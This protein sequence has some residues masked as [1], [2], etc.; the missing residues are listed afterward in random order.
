MDES[1]PRQIFPAGAQIFTEGEL[2]R[3]AYAIERGKV[4]ITTTSQGRRIALAKLGD[5]D[6]LGEMA[7]IDDSPR[8][9][10][11]IALEDTQVIVFERAALW[12][13]LSQADPLVR[14]LLAGTLDR[15]RTT[16]KV[17]L[18][19]SADTLG[20]KCRAG[21]VRE[22]TALESDLA[23]AIETESLSLHFQPIVRLTDGRVDGFEA[24]VRWEHPDHGTVVPSSFIKLA[25]ET[26]MI[27]PLGRWMLQKALAAQKEFEHAVN[28]AATN[29]SPY[30][31]VNISSRQLLHKEEVEDLIDL[32][33][34]SGVASE[35]VIFE[36]TETLLVEDPDNVLE[37]MRHF[38]A[39]GIRIA[40]D[41][42]GTG[43]ANLAFLNR[44]PLDILKIDRSFITNMV[45]DSR[46]R[47]IV[48]TIINLAQDFG[49]SIIAE[50]IEAEAE[51]GVLRE[52]GCDCGQGFLLSR[53][54]P[55]DQAVNLVR[56]RVRW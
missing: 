25:E 38:R 35:D 13:R 36:I 31:S 52:L 40:A 5:G 1:L 9:A 14:L 50:G 54:V 18:E 7:L 2:G 24:L 47:K 8:S 17:M 27:V 10:T 42:F 30:I 32:V 51:I 3:F 55:A 53:P 26:G 34:S 43:Y 29:V 49:M 19:Q 39:K 21:H 48:K 44:F 12:D 16:Q 15:L 37:A 20:S 33:Q 22:Q 45:E 11:A 46:S 56:Q 41:D 6:L 28:G 23:E 4:E